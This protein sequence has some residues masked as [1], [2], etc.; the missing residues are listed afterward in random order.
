MSGHVIMAAHPNILRGESSTVSVLAWN[1]RKTRTLV[2]SSL[3]ADM[4]RVLSSGLCGDFV[5]ISL[6]TKTIS[7][8]Q[9]P[10]A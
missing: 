8:R 4:F 5:V 1:S 7:K 10:C 6:N 9:E 2:R 3:G